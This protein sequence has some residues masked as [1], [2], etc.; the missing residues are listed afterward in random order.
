M[1]GKLI[2]TLRELH[3][4][5]IEITDEESLC[6]KIAG[7]CRDLGHGPFSHFFEKVYIPY[8]IDKKKISRSAWKHEEA[9]CR[10]FDMIVKSKGVAEKF[11]KEF[12]A[13]EKKYKDF[14]KDLISGL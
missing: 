2:D 10:L 3:R 14:I 6:V 5:K 9:S 4:E 7:L 12:G 8:M 1:C 11:S 13:D